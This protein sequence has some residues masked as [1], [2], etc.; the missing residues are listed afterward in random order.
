MSEDFIRDDG[1]QAWIHR[2]DLILFET[3]DTLHGDYPDLDWKAMF[4]CGYMP[5]TAVYELLGA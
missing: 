5:R 1:F 2:V 3:F 4:E